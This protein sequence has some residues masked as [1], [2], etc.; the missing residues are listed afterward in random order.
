MHPDAHTAAPVAPFF[1]LWAWFDILF[2]DSSNDILPWAICSNCC[3]W[4][5]VCTSQNYLSTFILSAPT[6]HLAAALGEQRLNIY[7]LNHVFLVL[8][9]HRAIRLF[10]SEKQV[11]LDTKPQKKSCT[12][13]K[14]KRCNTHAPTMLTLPSLSGFPRHFT[15]PA[16][17]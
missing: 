5:Q 15:L 14:A 12:Q 1:L 16:R 2:S 8:Q 13:H 10:L 4:M 3:K 17:S 7:L 6:H 11:L 9:L